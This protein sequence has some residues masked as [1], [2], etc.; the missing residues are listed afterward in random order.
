MQKL[1]DYRSAMKDLPP[2]VRHIRGID[3]TVA[4]FLRRMSDGKSMR[5]KQ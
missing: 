4:E 2:D 3:G 1:R 5:F